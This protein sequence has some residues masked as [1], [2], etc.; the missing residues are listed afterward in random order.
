MHIL[1]GLNVISFEVN[2]KTT[3][4]VPHMY[5]NIKSSKNKIAQLNGK[6]LV[7]ICDVQTLDIVTG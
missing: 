7:H 1:G 6:H 2:S 4:K 5:S 3:F